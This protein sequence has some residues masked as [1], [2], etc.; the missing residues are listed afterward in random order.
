MVFELGVSVWGCRYTH[1]HI[2]NVNDF[3]TKYFERWYDIYAGAPVCNLI[4]LVIW[5]IDGFCFPSYIYELIFMVLKVQ[6]HGYIWLFI[7][8]IYGMFNKKN[9]QLKVENILFHLNTCILRKRY[10][11]SRGIH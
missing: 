4:L 9:Y 5:L 7:G 10:S 11:K 2:R 8:F 6:L 1:V 3:Q